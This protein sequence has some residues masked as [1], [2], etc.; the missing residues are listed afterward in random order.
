M[1]RRLGLTV[2]LG[3]AALTRWGALNAA[4]P[5]EA[6][7]G[8]SGVPP[9]IQTVN[10]YCVGCHNDRART[11]GL[12]L[13][14]PDLVDVAT[15]P[16]VW[17]KVLR[18]VRG[19]MMPPPGATQPDAATRQALVISL[20]TTLVRAATASPNPG[21]PLA[22]RL[23]R[24]EYANAIRDLLSL[25]VDVASLLPPDDS[26]SGFDNNAD[27]LGVSPTSWRMSPRLVVVPSMRIMSA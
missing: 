18:K 27:V 14:A 3:L 9:H 22:H 23:N 17:E 26:S 15:H 2:A 11:G 5:Q 24:T 6:S 19:G 10:T 13:A 4:G 21:R 20:E 16:D 25:D 1:R 7:K 12:S 8:T